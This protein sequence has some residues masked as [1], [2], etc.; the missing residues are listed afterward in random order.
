MTLAIRA[1]GLRK[2][3]KRG[4]VAVQSLNLEIPH[5]E[6]FGF[7]G[8]NGAGKT[9]SVM[10]L[11]GCIAP[12]AGR[13]EL[14]GLPLGD[15]AARRRVGF[16]PEKFRFHEFLT[17]AEL[18]RVHGRL[19]GM[20]NADLDR[21]IPET[22]D[23]VG[24]GKRADSP[25]R[26][27]SKGMQQRVGLGQALIHDPDL[28][29]L[30]EPTSALDPLGRREVRDVLLHLKSAGKTVFLNSHLLSEVELCC[31]RVAVLNR[32][33]VVQQGSMS[34]LLGATLRIEVRALGVSESVMSEIKSVGRVDPINGAE[35]FNVFAEDGE[36]TERIAAILVNGGARV[37]AIT[38]HRETLE[39]FFVRV[40][41]G[42][43]E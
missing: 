27:F 6:V 20:S 12:T 35:H 33:S 37:R 39:D 30:D 19:A 10:M 1:E 25:I 43:S 32:G 18:L 7:L 31:D 16:L 28:L 36:A 4:A 42:G 14:F 34:E 15:P 26:E 8:L 17:A 24:L 2:V 11:L 13:G 38:P 23:L 21:R 9:T 5:G 41:E 29:V 3:Y 22:L 40:V